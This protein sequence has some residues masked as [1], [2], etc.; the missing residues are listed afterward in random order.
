MK[1]LPAVEDSKL[2][3]TFDSWLLGENNKRVKMN[4]FLTLL[5]KKRKEKK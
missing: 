3:L 5:K 4:E 1:T 2:K